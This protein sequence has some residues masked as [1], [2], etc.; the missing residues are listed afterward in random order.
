MPVFSRVARAALVVSLPFSFGAC[1]WFTDFK[2]QP[3]LEPWESFSVDVNDTLAAPRFNPQM[4]VPVQGTAMAGFAVSYLQSPMAVDSMSGLVNPHPVTE[5]SLANG[6]M[7]YAIN[8]MVCHGELADGNGGLRQFNPAYG[9]SPSLLTDQAMNRTDGY[10]WGM[11]RNGRGLMPSYARIEEA[12]RWDVVNYVRALQGKTDIKPIIGAPGMPG[13]NGTTVPRASA[14]APGVPSPFV[15][16]SVQLTP[17]SSGR[18]A[19]TTGREK[20]SF[21]NGASTSGGG[22]G[23]PEDHDGADAAQEMFE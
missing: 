14:T 21:P 10:I 22:T 19:A 4:S 7:H 17:G 9:F 1:T 15:P 5:E 11:M 16:G 23:H 2:N 8:C 18:N 13:Q 6:R 3:R 20:M 12:D